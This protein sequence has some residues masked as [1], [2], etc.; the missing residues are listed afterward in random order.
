VV[1]SLD[2][3]ALPDKELGA[4]NTFPRKLAKILYDLS[5]GRFA[6]TCLVVELR[7]VLLHCD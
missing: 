5:F 6:G 2:S 4:K 3:V 1:S 7:L